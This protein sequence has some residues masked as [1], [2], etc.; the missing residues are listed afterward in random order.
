MEESNSPVLSCKKFGKKT[1][2]LPES[3]ILSCG[4]KRKKPLPDDSPVFL[5]TTR[6]IKSCDESPVIDSFSSPPPIAKLKP[7]SLFPEVDDAPPSVESQLS[8]ASSSKCND[9]I[10]DEEDSSSTGS[11]DDLIVH[12]RTMSDSEDRLDIP[13]N[14]RSQNSISISQTLSYYSG[15]ST[16]EKKVAKAKPVATGNGLAK[17]LSKLLV[18]QESDYHLWKFQQKLGSSKTD[19]DP[20]TTTKMLRL[21]IE[22]L[23]PGNMHSLAHCRNLAASSAT[24]SRGEGSLSNRVSLVFTPERWERFSSVR[25]GDIV[26]IYE[27]WQ[28]MELVG[29]VTLLLDFNLL[30]LSKEKKKKEEVSKLSNSSDS[31]ALRLGAT[32]DSPTVED[33]TDADGRACSS[34]SADSIAVAE[35]RRPST[36]TVLQTWTCPCQVRPINQRVPFS[37]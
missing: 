21:R 26:S 10:I 29:G 33:L 23:S 31:D 15:I 32:N 18:R 30:L 4:R 35:N 1:H 3:P 28:S 14:A 19:A 36:V 13:D 20:A 25:S 12:E 6:T 22:S 16:P 8:Q 2:V 5:R 24:T 11:E 7:K 37:T 34:A 27:P 17:Q 9:H